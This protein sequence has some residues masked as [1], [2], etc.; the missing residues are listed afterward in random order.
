MNVAVDADAE[1][2]EEAAREHARSEYDLDA[3]E[4]ET[5]AD[6]DEFVRVAFL[7]RAVLEGIPEP[8][9]DPDDPRGVE[10]LTPT[11]RRLLAEGTALVGRLSRECDDR[12]AEAL[13]E[14]PDALAFED[15]LAR[16]VDGDASGGETA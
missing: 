7:R 6:A 4:V 9:V 15:R 14:Y 3:E 1:V 13:G 16:H 2:V 12:A 8:H 11:E 5:L 10:D